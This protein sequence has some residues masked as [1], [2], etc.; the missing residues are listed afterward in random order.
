MIKGRGRGW[1]P[2]VDLC[3]RQ[4]NVGRP[5][6]YIEAEAAPPPPAIGAAAVRPYPPLPSPSP[7]PTPPGGAQRSFRALSQL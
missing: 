2:Q 7:P 5:K 3:G 1:D 6:G 4:I